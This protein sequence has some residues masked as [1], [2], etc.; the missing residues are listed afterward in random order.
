MVS[1]EKLDELQKRMDALEIK[2]GDL[3][4]KFILGT[5]PGGQKVNKT[6]ACVYLKHL[7]SE[8]EVKCGKERS[9]ELNRFFARRKLCELLEKERFGIKSPKDKQIQKIRKQKNRRQRR[10]QQQINET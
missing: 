10:S 9:R 8:I 5:G 3:V 1:K 7:P 2:E 4:E 6:A